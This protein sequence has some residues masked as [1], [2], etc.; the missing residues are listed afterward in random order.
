[1]NSF[2]LL[3]ETF[4]AG[5][6]FSLKGL[7]TLQLQI[8]KQNDVILFYEDFGN[9]QFISGYFQIKTKTVSDNPDGTKDISF[10]SDGKLNIENSI[11]SKL[12]PSY[13]QFNP[14]GDNIS[15]FK[16]TSKDGKKPYHWDYKFFPWIKKKSDAKF[17]SGKIRLYEDYMSVSVEEPVRLQEQYFWEFMKRFRKMLKTEM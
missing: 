3:H 1:M 7:Q 10:C 11:N 5:K 6:Q 2:I 17:D 16:L 8:F 4:P 12:F 13:F 14:S 15:I 9:I